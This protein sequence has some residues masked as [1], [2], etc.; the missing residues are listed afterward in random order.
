MRKKLINGWLNMPVVDTE[1]IFALNPRDPKHNF[2]INLLKTSK[3]LFAPD[4]AL[5]EFEIVLRS[6]GRTDEE[7]MDALLS[8]DGIFRKYGVREVKTIGSDLLILHVEI[9]KNY[10]LIFFDSLIAASAS[11]ID[12]TIVSDDQA[13]DKI[14]DLKKCL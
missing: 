9:S 4:T 14:P 1:V 13:F 3:N 7:I 11:K 8:I 2:T 6:C 12:K 10:G 5:L